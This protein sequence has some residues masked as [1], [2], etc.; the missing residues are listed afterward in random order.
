MTD[1][2]SK[3]YTDRSS[4]G[5]ADVFYAPKGL[6]RSPE[7]FFNGDGR[8]AVDK[9]PAF[10]QPGS[11]LIHGS[12]WDSFSRLSTGEMA[13]P[14]TPKDEL[15]FLQSGRG[16]IS[17]TPQETRQEKPELVPVPIEQ[18]SMITGVIAAGIALNALQ[19]LQHRPTTWDVF[20]SPMAIIDSSL[21]AF[22]LP[23]PG[24]TINAYLAGDA[25]VEFD[26]TCLIEEVSPTRQRLPNAG[27]HNSYIL[28]ARAIIL[29]RAVDIDAWN[30]FAGAASAT[31]IDIEAMEWAGP[32]SRAM[33]QVGSMQIQPHFAPGGVTL[34]H[35]RADG[36]VPTV[37]FQTP[38]PDVVLA[39][40]RGIF[41][42]LFYAVNGS[43]WGLIITRIS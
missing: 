3:L 27:L 15:P 9:R 26:E 6:K 40:H 1:S 13:K 7:A 41:D 28:Q 32:Y 43:R 24:P 19:P 42:L 16:L 8:A 29:P 38:E 36:G 37:T 20:S 21:S 35:Y 31:N 17:A 2:G 22:R 4:I 18:D 23:D 5:T 14:R 12:G 30:L 39:A 34:N 11:G 10:H 33:P 25:D